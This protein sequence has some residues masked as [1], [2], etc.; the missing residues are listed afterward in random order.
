MK[1]VFPSGAEKHLI[2]KGIPARLT[3]QNI[4]IYIMSYNTDYIIS[5]YTVLFQY[6]LEDK[7][8]I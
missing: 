8:I 2:R 3:L 6:L 4:S 5:Y 1:N 7:F